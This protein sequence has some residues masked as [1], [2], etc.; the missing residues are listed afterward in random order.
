MANLDN[1]Y[2]GIINM[3]REQGG[4]NNAPN[5]ML[6]EVLTPL[7]ELTI[8]TGDIQLDKSNLL[9]ADYLMPDY[10]RSYSMTGV[11][12]ASTPDNFAVTSTVDDGGYNASPHSH[13]VKSMNFTTTKDNFSAHGDGTNP[14]DNDGTA[15]GCYLEFKDSF[16]I[17]DIVALQQFPGTVKFLIYCRVI[18]LEEQD[19]DNNG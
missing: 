4:K 18:S 16:K 2:A 13:S 11:M 3:M 8:K 17:G 15:E 14:A 5:L 7:P 19:G 1:P 10:K 6:G 9:I 12:H